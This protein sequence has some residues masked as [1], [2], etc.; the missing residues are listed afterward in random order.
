MHDAVKGMNALVIPPDLIDLMISHCRS[1]YPNEACGI[2]AGKGGRAEKIYAMTNAEPSPVSYLMDP[3]EQFAAM[4][5]MRTKG[6]DMIAIFHSHPQS[7]AYP[8]GKDVSLAFYSEAIYVIVS[9]I[10]RENP[11]IRGYT[12]QDGVVEE[13]EIR[14]QSR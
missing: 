11:E 12:I 2:L 5:E 1:G 4:K 13:V 8:S 14:R 7:P 6:L 3:S 9:F 10:N